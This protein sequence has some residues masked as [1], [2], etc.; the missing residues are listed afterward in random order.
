MV[1]VDQAHIPAQSAD[2]G[3]RKKQGVV[4]NRDSRSSGIEFGDGGGNTPIDLNKP[5]PR[6]I[7]QSV[8]GKL[9]RE[10]VKGD[11]AG[12]DGLI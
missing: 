6:N 9:D 3:H 12:L 1:D 8:V 7:L 5:L 4:M 11:Y 10:S 2:L